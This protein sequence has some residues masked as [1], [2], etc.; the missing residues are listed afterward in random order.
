MAAC[1]STAD[2]SRGASWEFGA[3]WRGAWKPARGGAGVAGLHVL[4]AC[5]CWEQW[6]GESATARSSKRR[7]RGG[8]WRRGVEEGEGRQRGVYGTRERPKAAGGTPEVAR[9]AGGRGKTVVAAAQQSSG[10]AGGGRRSEGLVCKFRKVQG[11][12]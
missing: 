5:S 12:D 7:N 10:G 9:A 8:A 2:G 3:P 4:N 1:N 6:A 11:L